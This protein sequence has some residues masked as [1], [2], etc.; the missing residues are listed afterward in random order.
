MASFVCTWC[1]GSPLTLALILL[2]SSVCPGSALS[3]NPLPYEIYWNV[4]EADPLG[5]NISSY[6]IFPANYTQTGNSCSNPG[7][8]TWTQGV[9]PTITSTGTTVNGGVPQ[10]ANLTEHLLALANGVMRWIPDPDWVGNAVLDFEAWTT[11]WELNTGSDRED[12]HSRRLATK[13]SYDFAGTYISSFVAN[14]CFS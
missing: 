1:S 14:Y 9:F 7:C 6:N 8:S 11:V 2:A 10:N 13:L 12:W 5:I 4:A 3:C